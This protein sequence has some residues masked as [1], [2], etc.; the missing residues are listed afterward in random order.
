MLA[1][2]TFVM[3]GVNLGLSNSSVEDPSLPTATMTQTRSCTGPR[4]EKTKKKRSNVAAGASG[5]N[6][7]GVAAGAS[8]RSE[9]SVPAGASVGASANN[10]NKGKGIAVD[11]P[12]SK[13]KQPRKKVI[14]IG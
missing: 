5:S 11:V 13:K 8:Q 6:A 2:F 12:G 9:P 10:L 1:F 3:L 4:V 7:A 14:N